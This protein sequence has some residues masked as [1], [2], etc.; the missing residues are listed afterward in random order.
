MYSSE[1]VG[2]RFTLRRDF[3]SNKMKGTPIGMIVGIAFAIIIAIA[4]VLVLVF[5][6]AIVSR[7]SCV[8][9]TSHEVIK[10]DVENHLYK[11]HNLRAAKAN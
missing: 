8:I 5:S 6:K 9:D 4:V 2:T 1:R 7:S 11:F 3:N 10:V